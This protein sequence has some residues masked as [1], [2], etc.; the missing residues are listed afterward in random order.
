[1]NTSSAIRPAGIKGPGALMAMHFAIE[2]LIVT[3]PEVSS[4]RDSDRISACW[5][6]S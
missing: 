1:L 4:V 2:A 5:P 3:N 6:A